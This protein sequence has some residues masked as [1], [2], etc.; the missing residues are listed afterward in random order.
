MAFSVHFPDMKNSD[1]TT[2]LSALSTELESFESPPSG[3][4]IGSSFS[5]STLI[6]EN[7][8]RCVCGVDVKD[9]GNF[10]Q[11]SQCQCLLHEKCLSIYPE[12]SRHFFVCPICKFHIDGTDFLKSLS[13][14]PEKVNM[15]I[16][17]LSRVFKKIDETVDEIPEKMERMEASM[18]NNSFDDGVSSLAA[19]MSEISKELAAKIAKFKAI[20]VIEYK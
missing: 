10:I 19:S 2:F 7:R 14:F 13:L 15:S 9:S 17:E 8:V 1:I 16:T 5:E 12:F 20:H 4:S 3:L 18:A 6:T 11:C